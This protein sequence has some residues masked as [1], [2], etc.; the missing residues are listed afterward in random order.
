[1]GRVVGVGGVFLACMSVEA[2]RRWYQRVLGF[3]LN[4]NGGM[5]FHHKDVV[6]TYP[7]TSRTIW[8][9]F[10]KNDDPFAPSLSEC[11]ISLIV[12]D[13]DSVVRRAERAGAEQVQPR[14]AYEY[15]RFAWFMDPDGRKVELWEPLE[16]LF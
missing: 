11:M 12:E 13:L 5:E 14:Q 7:T 4:K 9:T 15:G 3:E 8:A 10:D 2:T 1:M 6:K 16:P